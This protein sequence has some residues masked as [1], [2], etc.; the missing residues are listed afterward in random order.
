MPFFFRWLVVGLGMFVVPVLAAEVEKLQDHAVILQSVEHFI[1]AEKGADVSARITPLDRRLRLHRCSQPLSV[2]WPPGSRKSGAVSVGVACEDAK[3]WK[4]YVRARV[5]EY[6]NVAVLRRPL[7]RGERLTAADIGMERR[8]VSRLRG[9]YVGDA[10]RLV[11]YEARRGLREGEVL[12]IRMFR[13]P[14]LVRRGQRVILLAG[15]RGFEVKMPGKAL[16]DGGR[17]DR[18][19]VKNTRSRKIVEGE[20][21]RSGLV[22]VD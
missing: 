14:R 10:A 9:G 22:R 1:Q 19:R 8:D 5:V 17:G 13:A 11:G 20:V 15:R 21:V 16:A 6:R 18:I 4:I 2:F 12:T 3:P 7:A